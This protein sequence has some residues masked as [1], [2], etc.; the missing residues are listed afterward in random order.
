MP[1]WSVMWFQVPKIRYLDTWCFEL[2]ELLS[3]GSSHQNDSLGYLLELFAPGFEVSLV[4]E[5]LV[6]NSCA[7][8]WWV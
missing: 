3:Q 4:V 8:E 6:G 5:D 1:I 2:L 7:M